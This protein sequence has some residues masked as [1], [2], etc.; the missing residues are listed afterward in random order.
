MPKHFYEIDP[1]GQ[2][3]QTFFIYALF[4][5]KLYCFKIVQ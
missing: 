3:H 1:L 4:Y 5:Y 2:L